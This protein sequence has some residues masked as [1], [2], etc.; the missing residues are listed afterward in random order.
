[1]TVS[2][3]SNVYGLKAAS[4]VSRVSDRLSS[5]FEK[6]S[7][8]LRINRAS[9][10]PA[11]LAIADSLRADAKLATVAIRNANDG[12]SAT[13]IAD[14][15]LNEIGNMLARMAELAE[16]SANGIYTNSQRSA[17]SLEF[18]ALGSEIQRVA[19]TTEFNDKKLL[20]NSSNISIQVGF[21]SSSN[22]VINI[23]RVLGT[24]ESVGLA[25]TGSSSLRFSIIATTTDG[26]QSAS[27]FA[28]D[29]VNA[30]ISSLS[31]TRGKLGA[32]ESRL[33]TAVSYLS[34][35]RENL[36]AAESR[37]RDADIAQEVANMVQLQVLQQSA[38]AIAAQANQQPQVALSLLQ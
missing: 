3:A 27:Q 6:L 34:V 1:M 18:S 9:D 23:D 15:A 32:A 25:S 19:V 29:A 2:I 20:S 7:S 24:L 37:V 22:S 8:G 16:Q 10:D 17:L 4:Q 38:A 13:S 26:A 31:A 30:A 21:D 33:N 14:A 36:V 11:G 5:T 35:A 28:L 12:I